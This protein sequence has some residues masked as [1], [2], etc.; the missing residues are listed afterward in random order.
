M[1]EILAQTINSVAR[2]LF[3][4]PMVL[5]V[6][7]SY[8]ILRFPDV[9]VDGA[10]YLGGTLSAV[11]II[12][13]FDP[14]S[15]TLFGMVGGAA[16]GLCT[17]I[18]ITRFGIQRI[19]AGILVTMAL[20]SINFYILG[21]GAYSFTLDDVYLK[22]WARELAMTLFATDRQVY[23]MGT[24]LSAPMLS[25]LYVSL[26][27]ILVLL[28]VLILFFRTRFG[29]AMRAGG[30]NPSAART[31]GANVSTLTVTTLLLAN[32]LTGLSGALYAQ[33]LGTVETAAGLGQIVVGLACVLIGDAFF[34]RRSFSTRLIGAAVGALIYKVILGLIMLLGDIHAMTKLLTAAFVFLALMLPI[35][36]RGHGKRAGKSEVAV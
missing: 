2:G 29:L 34:Q 19:L 27:V 18:L 35:W 17:G 26:A 1:T 15:A 14:V 28:T 3:L 9:T 22:T 12:H 23:V 30:E 8:R 25:M 36:L 13:G 20:Y 24:G 4:V 32:A 6:F 7:I 16:A 31:V 5:G 21:Q 10:F 11:M 33:D